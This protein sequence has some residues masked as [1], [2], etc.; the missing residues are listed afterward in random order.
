MTDAV[1]SADPSAPVDTCAGWTVLDLVSHVVAVHNWARAAL[2]STDPPAYDEQPITGD[3]AQA[4][5]TAGR[6]LLTRIDE[7]ADD[8]P[9]WTLDRADRTAG[10]WVRR[11]L[12]ELVIHRWDLAPAAVDETLAEDGIDEVVDVLLPRQVRL[13]RTALPAG[14]L[15][16]ASDRR[17][18]TI[19][20][21]PRVTVTGSAGTLLLQL[22]GRG[23][24]LPPGWESLT[25]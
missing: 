15:H 10:F 21:P 6:A 8:N 17:T 23:R 11:Q 4:Y 12:F 24:A 19:G 3:L 5:S 25:P 16:L 2:D 1:A 13:G 22:W 14:G 18:W 9:A 20:T 7:V